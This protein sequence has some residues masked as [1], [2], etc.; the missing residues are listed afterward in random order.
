MAKILLDHSDGRY[1][2]TLLDEKEAVELEAKG[3]DVAYVH[4][5]VYAAYLRHCGQDAV[6]Q[7]LWQEISNAQYYRRRERELLPLEG[8]PARD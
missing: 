1:S 4:D 8:G 2:T 7:T 6:Y 5:W 3:T